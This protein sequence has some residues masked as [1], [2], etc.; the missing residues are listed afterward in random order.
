MKLV[1]QW[2]TFNGWRVMD[3]VQ[4]YILMK[5]NDK[6][7]INVDEVLERNVIRYGNGGD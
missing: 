3:K 1:K 5:V 2:S 6:K 7:E 4:T